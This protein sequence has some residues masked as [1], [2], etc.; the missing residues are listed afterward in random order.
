MRQ[1]S[2]SVR[3]LDLRYRPPRYFAPRRL[4]AH[5]LA[6]IQNARVKA[7]IQAAYD[8]GKSEEATDLLQTAVRSPEIMHVL[9]SVDPSFLGG[10]YL[11]PLEEGEVEIARLTLDSVTRDVKVAYAKPVH[12]RIRIRVL[13]EYDTDYLTAGPRFVARPLTL[14]HFARYFVE[15]IHLYDIL[16][17]NCVTYREPGVGDPLEA[18]LAFFTAQSDFY[19]NFDAACRRVVRQRCAH[20][21]A[22]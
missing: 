2:L 7:Q 1:T 9:E 8:A 20:W 3:P 10:N 14:G 21:T 15:T 5:L 18:A 4:E 12:R 16:E 22:T 13:D 17:M 19:P 11:P 6:Q